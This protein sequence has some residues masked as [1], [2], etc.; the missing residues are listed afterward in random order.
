MST[1]SKRKVRNSHS[2]PLTSYVS[3]VRGSTSIY[4]FVDRI[5]GILYSRE[6]LGGLDA[7][8]GALPI[9][10]YVLKKGLGDEMRMERTVNRLLGDLRT[11]KNDI[12]TFVITTRSKLYR[13]PELDQF[14]ASIKDTL[15]G[16]QLTTLRR[17]LEVLKHREV[18]RAMLRE[19]ILGA[20][21]EKMV[22]NEF[23][24]GGGKYLTHR[25]I[26]ITMREV[27]WELFIK[28]DPEGIQNINVY[29]PCAGSS[30][31]LT[32]WI[33]KI[34]RRERL[35]NNSISEYASRHLFGTD[36]FPEMVGVSALNMIIHGNG[37]SNIFRA[38]A[39]DHLGFLADFGSVI[40]FLQDFR[41]SWSRVKGKLSGSTFYRDVERIITPR[42]DKIYSLADEILEKISHRKVDIN[43]NSQEIEALYQTVYALAKM[44]IAL[45][46][47]RSLVKLAERASYPAIHF[48]MKYVWSKQNEQLKKGFN[49]I[50]T[51]PPMGRVGKGMGGRGELQITDRHILSQYGLATKMWIPI[52]PKKVLTPLCKR[53]GISSKEDLRHRLMD[54][55]GTEWINMKDLG[56]YRYEVNFQDDELGWEHPM[57]FDST[58]KPLVL[59]EALPIQV[60]MLEQFLRVVRKNG[61]LVF[62]VIDVG[63]LNNP[64]DEYVRQ[65]L[66]GQHAK[67]KAMIE[68]P[69]G[70]FRYCGSGT[71]TCLALYERVD[72]VPE[73]YEFFAS[74]VECM[75]YDIRSKEAIPQAENDLPK[76]ICEWKGTLGLDLPEEHEECGWEEQRTCRWWLKEF[77]TV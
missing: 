41:D 33:E 17:F 29:D 60:L 66:F 6:A 62:S 27:A 13:N 54:E 48:L 22:Y 39:T 46:E 31:F 49:L 5:H 74:D 69:H 18:L 77:E 51:N 20:L 53:K 75:G 8:K 59:L 19:D 47:L 44:D 72:K 36:K 71:K 9:V 28:E 50:M 23:K 42:E 37:V 67:I 2:M 16:I 68:L 61:G 10:A 58:W 35:P 57:F 34:K 65:F 70:A 56:Q 15:R 12:I 24:G 11:A 30:R 7:V 40:A 63:V 4:E 73:D 76:S 64:G 32:C 43:M 21:F 45:K 52:A 55:L 3:S 1:S 38:D 26:V 14:L 25:N